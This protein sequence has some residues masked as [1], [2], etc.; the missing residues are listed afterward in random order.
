MATPFGHGEKILSFD[1]VLNMMQTSQ[2]FNGS[3]AFAPRNWAKVCLLLLLKV[4]NV[5]KQSSSHDENKTKPHFYSFSLEDCMV[6]N[7]PSLHQSFLRECALPSPPF[8]FDS[9]FSLA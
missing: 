8:E 3:R 2:L 5:E 7:L 6:G 4:S 1:R 9:V